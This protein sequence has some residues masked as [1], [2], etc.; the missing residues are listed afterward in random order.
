M[1]KKEKEKRLTVILFIL[2][3]SFGAKRNTLII[4]NFYGGRLKLSQ[5]L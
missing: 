3:N 5:Y 4:L 2:C 1:K